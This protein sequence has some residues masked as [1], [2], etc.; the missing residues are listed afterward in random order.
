MKNAKSIFNTLWALALVAAVSFVVSCGGDDDDAPVEL[1]IVSLN[2]GDDDL[3]G[4]TSPTGVSTTTIISGIFSADLD[5]ATAAA[6]VSLVSDFDD[7]QVSISVVASGRSLT[8]TPDEELFGGSLYILTIKAGLS[9]T[10]GKTLGTDLTRNFT[11]V[12]TFTPT[13]V[14]A[15]WTFE[16]N[17]NDVVGDFD[18][19]AEVAI[20]Y[21]AS[22]KAAAG[23][24]ATFDGDVSIIEVP[25]ADELMNTANF[26]L[27]YWVKTN[28]QGHVNAAGEPAG[29]FVMGLGAF[30][31]FQTEISAGY[32][33]IKMPAMMEYGDGTLGTGGDIFWNGDG[34]TKDNEGWQGT[35]VNKSNSDLPSSLKDVWMHYT[36]IFS[37]DGKY[38]EMYI[39]G[40]MVVRQDLTLWPADAK[41]PTAVGLKF[42]SAAADVE[43]VL[44]FGFVQSRGGTLW[45]NEPWGSYALPTSNHF[46]GQL[47]DIRIFSVAITEEEVKLMYDSEKP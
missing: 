38:R 2:A 21:T 27:S 29:H 3:N 47:D 12:G 19:N 14:I 36:Y 44:A 20:T 10:Q 42:N 30:N 45:A 24:A 39:N 33:F 9:S 7:S 6:N 23:K 46:K 22:R 35:V 17:A 34:K 25:G 40:Q 4:A 5:P 37:G 13:N 26:T 28:S 16:D 32:D 11:T 41:E 15:H 18:A 8:I 1:T 43:N 31:G